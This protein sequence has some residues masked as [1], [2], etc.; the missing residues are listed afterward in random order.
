MRTVVYHAPGEYGH[1]SASRYLARRLVEHGLRFVYLSELD[2]QHHIEGDGFEYVPYLPEAY[3][4]GGVAARHKLDPDATWE[5]WLQRDL[6]MWHEA[7][8]G[9][10][11]ATLSALAPDLVISDRIN[12]DTSLVA[13]KMRVPF[14]RCSTMLPTYYQVDVPPIW[15]DALPG[16]LSR[17][18]LEAEWRCHDALLWIKPWIDRDNPI[19]RRDFYKFVEACG[20]SVAQINYRDAFNYHVESDPEMITCSRAFDFPAPEVPHRVYLGPCLDA[21]PPGAWTYPGR[22]AGSPLVYCGFGSMG[23]QYPAGKVVIERLIAVA[24]ARPQLDI[25]ISIPDAVIAGWE[26]PPTVHARSWL[27]Q[28]E[29][30]READ[31]FIT[32]AG[33]ASCREAIWEGV[34]LLAVPFHTDQRGL[35]AR[36]VYHGLGER[37]L[38]SIPPTADVL[39]LVDR[40]L[41]DPKYRRAAERM[42]TEFQTADHDLG[43]RFATDVM[44]GRIQTTPP[45]YHEDLMR[46]VF[47]GMVG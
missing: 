10:L 3:P 36:I 42:Q 38:G 21:L 30:L 1:Y 7:S 26:L 43:V 33:L 29:V 47:R 15:S 24:R 32:H 40:M 14:I 5:W 19:P 31:L 28:R 9:R 11:E 41:A 8:S 20:V 6:A 34:P 25:V 45:A 17:W 35:A 23:T 22:R 27:P 13:H 39:D 18:E 16:E 46:K 37:M 44:T 4:R 2:M 12:P